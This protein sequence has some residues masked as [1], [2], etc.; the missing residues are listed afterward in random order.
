[1]AA[2]GLSR[3]EVDQR[4]ENHGVAAE[5]DHIDSLTFRADRI[6]VLE[7]GRIVECGP[8]HDLER[9]GGAFQAQLDAAAAPA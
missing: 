8:P 7:E 4:R 6:V 1:M 9:A 5:E 2:G 3:A